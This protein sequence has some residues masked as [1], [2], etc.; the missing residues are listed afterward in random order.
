[1]A[2]WYW[3]RRREVA[4]ESREVW[5]IERSEESEAV[6]VEAAV[7]WSELEAASSLASSEFI[8]WDLNF[9]VKEYF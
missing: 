5:S 9:L 3:S 1:L 6:S 2:V 8:S 4:A 7:S